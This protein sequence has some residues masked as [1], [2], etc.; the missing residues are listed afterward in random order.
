[1]TQTTPNSDSSPIHPTLADAVDVV[2]LIKDDSVSRK[3]AHLMGTLIG[4]RDKL[5]E[6]VDDAIKTMNEFNQVQGPDI[7]LMFKTVS[8]ELHAVRKER[9][10]ARA[11]CDAHGIKWEKGRDSV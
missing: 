8:F 7:T 10:E 4:Q 6:L 3:A 1:M 2:L 11:L 9:D 5:S